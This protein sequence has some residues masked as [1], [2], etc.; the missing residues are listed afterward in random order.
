MYLCFDCIDFRV[1]FNN[2]FS[3]WGNLNSRN[4][5]YL[6]S[7]LPLFFSFRTSTYD[8]WLGDLTR[9]TRITRV[10]SLLTLVEWLARMLHWLLI[11]K[12]ATLGWS[13]SDSLHC[14]IHWNCVLR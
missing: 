6:L 8:H 13:C 7:Y 4:L 1:V 14:L 5:L 12:N 10:I 3:P 11:V 9:V 2:P